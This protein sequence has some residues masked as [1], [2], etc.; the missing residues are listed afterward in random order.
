MNINPLN[1]N[2]MKISELTPGSYFRTPKG[3]TEYQYQGCVVLGERKLFLV[4]ITR[5]NNLSGYYHEKDLE[6]VSVP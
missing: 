6:V 5:N 4:S 2:I 3:K 1:Q